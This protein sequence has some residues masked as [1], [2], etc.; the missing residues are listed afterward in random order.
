MPCSNPLEITVFRKFSFPPKKCRHGWD[1][2]PGILSLRYI[3]VKK[4]NTW[5][6]YGFLKRTWHICKKEQQTSWRAIV[7]L[8][9]TKEQQTIAVIWMFP[10]IVG[11]FPPKSSHFDRGFPWFSPSILGDFIPYFWFNTHMQKYQPN[12]P[13]TQKR[14]R[15]F[16]LKDRTPRRPT[17]SNLP[18]PG[19]KQTDRPPSLPLQ[20]G[21]NGTK[22]QHHL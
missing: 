7:K 10:K 11:L 17:K 14:P 6:S 8:L 20:H 19:T 5:Y 9:P 21:Q 16:A 22:S 4:N 1:I 2:H 18:P 15:I 13:D 12:A 3:I